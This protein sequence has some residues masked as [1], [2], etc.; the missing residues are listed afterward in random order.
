MSK[1]KCENVIPIIKKL[2]G[3]IKATPNHTCIHNGSDGHHPLLPNEKPRAYTVMYEIYTDP[4]V[5]NDLNTI[6]QLANFL[7][8]SEIYVQFWFD[9]RTNTARVHFKG[10][11]YPLLCKLIPNFRPLYQLAHATS[12]LSVHY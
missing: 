3:S 4:T 5:T 9:Y 6:S 1:C 11:D 2:E 7:E 12:Q 8:T 10:R